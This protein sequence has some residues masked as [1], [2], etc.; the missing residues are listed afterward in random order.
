[1]SQNIEPQK[2]VEQFSRN[3][4][5]GRYDVVYD[6]YS[7]DSEFRRNFSKE[8]FSS[9]MRSTAARTKMEIREAKIVGS[10]VQ[11]DNARIVLLSTTKS[12]VG[13]W[14]VEEEF[15]LR[16]EPGGWKIVSVSKARQWPLK[17]GGTSTRGK[18]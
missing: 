13:E 2:V 1:M 16:R 18:M 8:T 5:M 17:Q 14:Y 15:N 6:L 10:E 4:R 9:R 11:G 7:Q 12:I 3:Y